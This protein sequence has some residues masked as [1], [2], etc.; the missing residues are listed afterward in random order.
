MNALTANKRHVTFR[1]E[2]Q[3]L[4]PEDIPDENVL[5]DLEQSVMLQEDMASWVK[6]CALLKLRSTLEAKEEPWDEE[7]LVEVV[8]SGSPQRDSAHAC[9]VVSSSSPLEGQEAQ[10]PR[11]TI[12]AD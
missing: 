3:V 2:P 8:F 1:E 5:R 12:L 10:Q 6:H 11:T 4:G 7:A 9:S